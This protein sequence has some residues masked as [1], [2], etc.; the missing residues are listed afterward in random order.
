MI[1]KNATK[2]GVLQE[3]NLVQV[4]QLEHLLTHMYF[5]NNYVTYILLST[6]TNVLKHREELLLVEKE[7]EQRTMIQVSQLKYLFR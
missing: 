4:N 5:F 7:A 1:Y 2:E 6:K 3:I